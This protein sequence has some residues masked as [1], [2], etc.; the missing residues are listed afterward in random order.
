MET[1]QV[2]TL[3]YLNQRIDN[4]ALVVRLMVERGAMDEKPR[5]P[6]QTIVQDHIDA[7]I[8]DLKTWPGT[9][10]EQEETL[11]RAL[12]DRKVGRIGR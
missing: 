2:P 9:T 6:K 7:I 5:E 8:G 1:P 4:L 10:R 11:G 3:N 12:Q